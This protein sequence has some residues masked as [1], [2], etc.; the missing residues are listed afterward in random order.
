MKKVVLKGKAS[1]SFLKMVKDSEDKKQLSIEG[2][3][4]PKEINDFINQ[5]TE[6]TAKMNGED[7]DKS[8]FRLGMYAM[9]FHL[10][11]TTKP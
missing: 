4:I 6:E 7:F 5:K 8:T 2:N 10:K 3:K 11:S 1:E 9:Y